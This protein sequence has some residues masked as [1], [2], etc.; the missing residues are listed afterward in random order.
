[1]SVILKLLLKSVILVGLITPASG[2]TIFVAPGAT[3]DENTFVSLT[4]AIKAIPKIRSE[5]R[6][7]DPLVIELAPGIHRISE[8]IL[9]TSSNSGI[10]ESMLI[11]RGAPNGTS[12]L[13]GSVEVESRP[14]V[15]GDAPETSLA[16]GVR[17]AALPTE[18]TSFFKA[19]RGTY[20]NIPNSGLEA[21][22]NGQRLSFARWPGKDFS[23]D[24]AVDSSETSPKVR[25][26]LEKTR[27]FS[28]EH[29]M[30]ISGYW[31]RDWAYESVPVTTFDPSSQTFL[32]APLKTPFPARQR[33]RFFVENILSSLD[34]P[35]KMVLYAPSKLFY[36]PFAG[37][38]SDVSVAVSRNI[39]LVQGA[40]HI[41][42][43]RLQ[44][45]QTLAEAIR[46]V[47]SSDIEVRECLIRGTGMWGAV[48]LNS[49]RVRFEDCTVSDTAEGGIFLDGGNRKTLKR[50]D[51]MVRNTIIT[52]FGNENPAYRPG[53]QLQ[54]VGNSVRESYIGHG[55]HSGVIISG[56]DNTVEE[57]ELTDLVTQTDDAG[58]VYMGRD[59]TMRGNSISGN[60]IHDIASGARK[61]A[62]GIY[63]DDQFSGTIID[64]N[65]FCRVNLP[66]LLG[67]G[68]DNQISRN[69]F[70]APTKPALLADD[71]GLTWQR[72]M[73]SAELEKRL[74]SVPVQS[75]IWKAEYPTLATLSAQ[76][77]GEP[78]GN[79]LVSNIVVGGVLYKFL[80][81]STQGLTYIDDNDVQPLVSNRGNGD[82]TPASELV[83][84]FLR[85]HPHL[86][87]KLSIAPPVDRREELKRR[88]PP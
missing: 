34:E 45:G 74:A 39:F 70:I 6:A 75:E 31:A 32:V 3:P 27:E 11:V 24:I 62:V 54:G 49:D 79:R 84:N 86:S 63:L 47:N 57:N 20:A 55:P 28:Q 22:Q 7:G 46:I 64:R 5:L 48:V 56:N 1:M 36:F 16:N 85:Q 78:G 4:D 29:A 53:I 41:R 82:E 44:L 72:Q 35:G 10:P 38:I 67:G 30:W 59:W 42:I 17:V 13:V 51:N 9:L 80:G 43:E 71:R 33:F 18:R 26:S 23:E 88:T 12:Q 81:T 40:H 2:R 68:R 87:E 8:P 21:F 77:K 76:Q 52:N 37:K 25:L 66:I 15:P 83:S 65:L 73:V 69:L 61:T 50:S 14:S 58:A 19:R 60:F